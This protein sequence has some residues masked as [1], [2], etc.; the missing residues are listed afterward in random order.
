MNQSRPDCV[1]YSSVH[2]HGE[3]CATVLYGQGFVSTG[4][5]AGRRAPWHYESTHLSYVFSCTVAL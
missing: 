5:L 3:W 4:V 1:Q 2:I